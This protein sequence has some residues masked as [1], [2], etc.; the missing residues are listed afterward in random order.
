MFFQDLL[1][2][3]K[4]K[5]PLAELKRLYYSCIHKEDAFEVVKKLHKRYPRLPLYTLNDEASEWMNV[6]IRKFD[7]KRYFKDFITSGYLGFGKPDKRIY[8]ILL[9]RAGVKAQDCLFIDNKEPL[10]VPAR[11]L[12]F[13]TILFIDKSQLAR[14]LINFGIN[15]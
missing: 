13:K 15:L 1:N 10:L 14:D 12:G 6:R 7:L 5:I 11:E 9:E 2:A 3:A 4:Q 8:E